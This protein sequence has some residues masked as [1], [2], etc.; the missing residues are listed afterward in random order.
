MYYDWDAV[1]LTLPGISCVNPN[2]VLLLG[3]YIV[4]FARYKMSYIA[5]VFQ[6]PV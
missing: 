5:G 2:N 6:S 1:M 3:Y 4:Y